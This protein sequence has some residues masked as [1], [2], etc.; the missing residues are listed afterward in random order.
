MSIMNVPH[1]RCVH[2]TGELPAD[3]AQRLALNADTVITV[4]GRTGRTVRHKLSGESMAIGTYVSG[5]DRKFADFPLACFLTVHER[6]KKR[7]TRYNILLHKVDIGLLCLFFNLY[8]VEVI[9]AGPVHYL[10]T[11]CYSTN[12]RDTISIIEEFLASKTSL[13]QSRTAVTVRPRI[14]VP[15]V[16]PFVVLVLLFV[17]EAIPKVLASQKVVTELISLSPVRRS[18]FLKFLFSLSFLP[19]LFVFSLLCFLSLS[20]FLRV[21]E[22]FQVRLLS[23]FRLHLLH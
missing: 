18:C 12:L 4:R 17:V 7:A 13:L 20:S 15:V 3:S 22:F 9:P 5:T 10:R 19:F 23:P 6:T 2:R 11:S 21:H 1:L 16:V 14:R 8:A